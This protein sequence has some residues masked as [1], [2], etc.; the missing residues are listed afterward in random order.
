MVDNKSN[1]YG[2][3]MVNTFQGRNLIWIEMGQKTQKK[4]F[5]NKFSKKWFKP[6][7]EYLSAI[8]PD[9]MK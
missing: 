2:K 6:I 4:V 5:F 3:R 8:C 9:K 1:H 7:F